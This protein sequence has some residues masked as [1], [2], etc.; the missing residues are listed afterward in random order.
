MANTYQ[1][2]FPVKDTGEDGFAALRRWAPSLR[3]GM[4]STTWLGTSGN[5]AAT[6]I[7]PIISDNLPKAG[8]VARNPQGPETP[9]D[10]AEP[11]EKKSVQKGGSFLCTDQYC[12]R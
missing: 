11:T 9:F 2:V 8:N 6:G 5:G 10:P 4:A 7:A 1:G 12:I 3:M